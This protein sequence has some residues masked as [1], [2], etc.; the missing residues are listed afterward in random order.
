[1]DF[2][3]ITSYFNPFNGTLR[4]KNYETF[5]KHL[6]VPL[7]TVEWS[8]YADFTLCNQDADYLL[9]VSGGDILWQKE[10]LLNIGLSRARE[11]GVRNAALVDSDI[12]FHE[13]DWFIKV[14]SSLKSHSIVQCFRQVNYLP[15]LDCSDMTR[16]EI[17]RQQPERIRLSLGYAFTQT[18]RF[19]PRGLD[20]E[21]RH[22]DISTSS[23]NPGMAVALSMEK[24][25]KLHLYEAN[26][27]GGGDSVLMAG[28]THSIPDL[29]SVRPYTNAHKQ[30]ILDW[31]DKSIPSGNQLG[32]ADNEIAHLWHGTIESRQYL[33]RHV[34]LSK[35]D[36]VPSR[37]INWFKS[38]ALELSE[39]GAYLKK[40]ILH[41]M[42]SRESETERVI[43]QKKNVPK[44]L[45]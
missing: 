40:L 19:L 27:V 10:R 41:Y 20:E 25:A 39:A 29:F 13:T 16:S 11:L 23:G 37:D 5:R 42:Q 35:C 15:E 1:M 6:G 28:A 8:P 45:L 24:L 18:H 44:F 31:Y 30:S 22:S 32:Y 34:I 33:S 12:V 9:Q 4:R 38:G 14:L 43:D 2:L 3:A 17:S 26:I 36:Y 21:S 7:L